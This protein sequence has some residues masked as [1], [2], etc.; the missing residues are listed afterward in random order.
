M[1]SMPFLL[2]T[3]EA[4]V[5]LVQQALSAGVDSY[6]QKPFTSETLKSN[7]ETVFHSAKRKAA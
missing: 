7:L 2:L 3:A 1:K 4:D 5:N 6:L